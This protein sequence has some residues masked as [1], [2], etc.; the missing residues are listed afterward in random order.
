MLEVWKSK[1][2]LAFFFKI[3][4]RQ[5]IAKTGL[6]FPKWFLDDSTGT[7]VSFHVRQG[8]MSGYQLY[9]GQSG[10]ELSLF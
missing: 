2:S 8:M 5:F 3:V 1:A 4:K 10:C 6:C 9:I 7:N